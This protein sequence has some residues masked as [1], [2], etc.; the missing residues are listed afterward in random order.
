MP[1]SSCT[2]TEYTCIW[3]EWLDY[4]FQYKDHIPGVID[5][6]CCR[7]TLNYIHCFLS[8]ETRL[9]DRQMNNM[10]MIIFILQQCI[11]K[12]LKDKFKTKS[13]AIYLSP[14]PWLFGG[15]V[16]SCFPFKQP[17]GVTFSGPGDIL[18]HGSRLYGFNIIILKISQFFYS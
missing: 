7:V 8:Y 14:G 3:V 4:V 2:L 13:Y 5:L 10:K 9:K 1:A 11:I 12:F 18:C 16:F 6:Y 15:D 17:K